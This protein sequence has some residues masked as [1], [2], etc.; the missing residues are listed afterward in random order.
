MEQTLQAHYGQLLGLIPPWAV[1]K[2]DLD[3][4]G[5]K[6]K[7][8]VEYPE[9]ETVPCPECGRMCRIKD[10][11]EERTWR[12]L[13]T[14][15]FQTL[16]TSRVPRSDCPEHGAKTIKVPWAGQNS[17]FTLLFER[18]AIDV[19]SGARSLTQAQKLL[20]LSWS[21][22]QRIMEVAV[23]R[24]LTRRNMDEMRAVGIDEKSFGRGHD[25]VTVMT[26]ID[27]HRVLDIVRGRDE[28]ACDSLWLKISEKQRK[29]I[30]AVAMDMWDAFMASTRKNVSGADIV[31]DKFHVSKYLCKAVDDVRKKEHKALR[32]SGDNRL[33]G[34]KYVWLTGPQNWTDRHREL[35]EGLRN[36]ALKVGRAWS[37]KEA[38]SDFWDY[39]YTKSA[40]RFFQSWFWWATHSRLVPIVKTAWTLKRHIV[41]LLAYFKHRI[42]NAVAEGFNSKIQNIKSNAR[43]FR[44][45]NNYRIA[46]LFHC[47]K[48]KLYP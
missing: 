3:V 5:L 31:H 48:L 36:N 12:H 38:F 10:H 17:G 42:T 21:Q 35:F 33:V 26:D 8:S 46:I 16:V 29:H 4:S 25:Y 30:S 15:Q 27:G 2:V 44:N 32:K 13:D 19:I 47:G 34:S 39:I 37:I 24:G 14:M 1:V 45:F 20:R 18:F 7:I 6:V 40:E 11:R 28:D 43:G 22:V 9:G 41:G 23:K